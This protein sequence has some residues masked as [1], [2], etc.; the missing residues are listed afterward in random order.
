MRHR[1][2]VLTVPLWTAAL[3]L[4]GPALGQGAQQVEITAQP[5][6]EGDQRRRDPVART[7]VGRD[8]LEK[9]GDIAV[10]DVLKRQPGVTMQGGSPRLRGLGGSYTLLLVNG[11]PAPPGFRRCYA[12]RFPAPDVVSRP[13]P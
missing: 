3:G 9:Y 4:A 13:A 1:R 8:E 6:S 12:L 11:E 5:P 2:H 10:T 7:I